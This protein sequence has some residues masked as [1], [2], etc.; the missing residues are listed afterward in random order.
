MRREPRPSGA[1]GIE[2]CAQR[3]W[4]RPGGPLV[5]PG[6]VRAEVSPP[7]QWRWRRWSP[8]CRDG[9]RAMA[10]SVCVTSRPASGAP[11]Q[12]PLRRRRPLPRL[13]HPSHEA[14]TFE[15]FTLALLS[16]RNPG[17][18][19]HGAREADRFGAMPSWPLRSG[20]V[21][22]GPGQNLSA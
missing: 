13:V 18:K 5:L 1:L 14:L 3:V 2:A 15:G 10:V 9:S 7:I 21:A 11:R 8:L 4:R 22:R 17:Y 16:V 12:Q 19:N 20:Y 6:R